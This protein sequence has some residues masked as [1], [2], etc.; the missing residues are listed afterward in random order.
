MLSEEQLKA[1]I[2]KVQA[3]PPLQ[4]QPKSEGDGVVAVA[5]TVGLSLQKK[6]FPNRWI[7]SFQEKS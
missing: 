5:K 1:F 3:G 4:E 2:A 6:T 7:L